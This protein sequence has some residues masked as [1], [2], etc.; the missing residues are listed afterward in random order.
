MNLCEA[1]IGKERA[2]FV[3]A[4]AGG[5]V[6]AVRVRRQIKNVAVAACT[7]NDSIGDVGID[8]AGDQI[9]RDDT[10]STSVDDDKIEHLGSRIHGHRAGLHLTLE[11]LISAEKK[12][13]SRLAPRIKC[14][15]HLRA[16]KRTIRQRAA[17]F[18]RKGNALRNAL[19]DDMNADLREAIDVGFARAE[20][21]ALYRVVKKP[22]DAVAIILII[23]GRVDAALC[24][25]GVRAAR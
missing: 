7:E 10:T 11:C 6:R 8:F 1:G 2:A 19:I 9:A 25:D 14:T 5:D 15:R 20:I 4:P 12:L 24:G 22:P 23:L 18:T 13:L 16:T 17:V 3:S 21:A